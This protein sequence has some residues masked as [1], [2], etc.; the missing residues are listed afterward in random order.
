MKRKNIEVVIGFLDAIR[1]RDREAAAGFLDP[2]VSWQGVVPDLVCRNSEEV[3]GIFF[4]RRNDPG[5]E[6]DALEIIGAARG[7]VFAIHHPAVWAV[8]GTEIRGVMYHA[9]EIEAGR[10]RRL[11]D[12]PDRAEA[13]SAVGLEAG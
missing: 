2:D 13:L 1:R 7:A 6:I 9:A 5:V 8:A 11:R 12:Y 10:I 4:R 3:L